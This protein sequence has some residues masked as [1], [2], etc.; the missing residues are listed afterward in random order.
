MTE[1]NLGDLTLLFL[2]G[3]HLHFLD[4]H[5]N[6]LS[7]TY[8]GDLSLLATVVIC[9]GPCEAYKMFRMEAGVWLGLV[10]NIFKKSST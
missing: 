3:L 5:R 6:N 1:L 2:A 10:R 9:S 4:L 7:C 8:I